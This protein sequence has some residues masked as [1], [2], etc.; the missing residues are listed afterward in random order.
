MSDLSDDDILHLARQVVPECLHR[1]GRIV[2]PL[3]RTR[4]AAQPAAYPAGAPTLTA[5]FSATKALDSA[6]S[7]PMGPAGGPAATMTDEGPPS[8]AAAAAAESSDAER[9]LAGLAALVGAKLAPEAPGAVSV[10]FSQATIGGM[11]SVVVQLVDG[12]P[13]RVMQLG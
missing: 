3:P 1:S 5:A 8:A 11:L 12:K 6:F 4:G 7:A 2:R 10:E 13:V 9:D